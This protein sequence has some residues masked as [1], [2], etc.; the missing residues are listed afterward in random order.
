LAEEGERSARRLADQRA[1]EARR[2]QELERAARNE[3]DGKALALQRA[4]DDYDLL[5]NVVKLREAIA[6]EADLYPAWPERASAMRDWLDQQARPL[7]AALPRLESTLAELRTRAAPAATSGAGDGLRFAV[8]A[9]QFLHDTLARLVDDLRTFASAEGGL[10]AAVERRLQWA[11][12]VVEESVVK[13]ER[14]WAAATADVAALPVYRG[15]RLEPQLDLVP[16]RR[17]PTSQL[18]EFVHLRSGRGGKA[19][20]QRNPETRQ[21][22][23]TEDSGI[24]FVLLPPS[25]F[26]MGAQA[27]D[28]AA[29]NHDPAATK[30]E[31]PC[32]T[33]ELAAFFLAK[34]EMTQ[35]Q[36]RRLSEGGEPSAYRPGMKPPGRAH[37][38]SATNPVENV[39]WQDCTELLRKHGLV[40]PTEAQWEYAC[41]ADTGT[42]WSSGTEA[43]SLRG[44]AN[45]ADLT[46]QRAGSTWPIE[47]GFDDG[48]VVHAPVGTF[49]PNAF[50]MFDMHGNVWEWCQDGSGSYEAERREGDGLRAAG[51]D[52]SR[53]SRGGSFAFPASDARSAYRFFDMAGTRDA[54]LGLRAARRVMAR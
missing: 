36:W 47:P 40:L 31:Q 17:D 33:V 20:P 16:L 46:A 23:I 54:N 15:L 28:P 19:I 32:R 21:L 25:T 26:V 29:A 34:H 7:A 24:V 35:A 44:H 11:E 12:A 42:P 27:D 38:I 41:R 18:W 30:Q 10:L 8:K 5:A 50:G 49:R 13:Y 4:L 53:V 2:S 51:N 43:A 6:A 3:A 48:H 52:D 45:L 9:E 22:E 1:E 14:E 37:E 39:S